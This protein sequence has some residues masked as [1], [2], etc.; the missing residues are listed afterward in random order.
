MMACRSRL[1]LAVVAAAIAPLLVTATGV[2]L[3]PEEGID[4]KNAPRVDLVTRTFAGG[5]KAFWDIFLPSF[6]VSR[7]GNAWQVDSNVVPSQLFWPISSWTSSGVVV[8]LDGENALDHEAGTIL[9][10]MNFPFVF[11]VKYEA[12]APNGTLCG[13]WR[14]EGYARQ[15]YSNFYGN[16][17]TDAEYVAII[18]TDTKIIAPGEGKVLVIS[19]LGATLALLSSNPSFWIIVEFTL[20]NFSGVG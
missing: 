8:I 14:K 12:P 7:G 19:L 16:L 15:Q 13:D 3:E 2:H 9:Q 11:Q 20:Y 17:Y 5:V 6:L 1:V 18:D 10:H 4:W